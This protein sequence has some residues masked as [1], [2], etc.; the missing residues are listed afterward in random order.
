MGL[1]VKNRS[2]GDY[3]N[4]KTPLI[5]NYLFSAF[6]GTTWYLQFFFYTMGESKIGVYKFSSWALHIASII[7][8]STC[9]GLVLREWKGSSW[10][11]FVLLF[12]GLLV[13]INAMLILLRREVAISDEGGKWWYTP[14]P[15]VKNPSSSGSTR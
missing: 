6:A 13:L 7:V 9:W 5:L 1:A 2:L 11:T 4:T 14:K 3:T 8:F 10:R 12:L 15:A